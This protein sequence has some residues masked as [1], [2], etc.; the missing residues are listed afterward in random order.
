M[1][2]KLVLQNLQFEELPL[3]LAS[4]ADARLARHVVFPPQ[5]CVMNH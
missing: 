4:L 1:Q 3:T 5:D 2:E